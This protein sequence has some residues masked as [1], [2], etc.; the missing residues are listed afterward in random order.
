MLGL[1]DAVRRWL[2]HERDLTYVRDMDELELIDLGLCRSEALD[3]AGAPADTRE[4]LEAMAWARGLPVAAI[5]AE[6]WR[7]ADMARA[8]AQ[9]G[10]RRRCRRW[11]RGRRSD[12]PEA[13]CPNAGH[14]ADLLAEEAEA[15]APALR[16]H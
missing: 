7:A 9:C 3:L 8:C 15:A 2:R 16:A 14:F 12:D 6:H 1:V 4:R 10:E 13:F 11:L 5:D